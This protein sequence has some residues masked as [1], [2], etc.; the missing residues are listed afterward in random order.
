M[1]RLMKPA[2]TGDE[3][4]IDP[5][6]LGTHHFALRERLDTRW[7]DDTDDVACLA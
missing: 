6:C 7:V 2:K 5:V 1:D 3:S 4:C